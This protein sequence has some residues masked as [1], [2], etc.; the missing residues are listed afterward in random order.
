MSE[1]DFDL[2]S[3]DKRKILWIVLALNAALATAFFATGFL[4]DSSALIANGLDNSSDAIVYAI[5]LMALGRP[6]K[7]K[8]IAARFSGI[9]LLA[10]AGGVMIDAGRRFVSGSEPI[11]V[12]MM[13]MA[14]VAAAVNLLSLCLLRRLRGKDVNLRAATTFSFNDFVSNGGIVIGGIVVLWTGQNWP[15]LVVGIGVA[16]IAIYGGIDILRDARDD[17]KKANQG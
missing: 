2:R 5:S 1:A 16:S 4:G 13:G 7:W 11:G 8:R 15:D 3:R 17:A 12:M 10:F 9:M 6:P 14:L